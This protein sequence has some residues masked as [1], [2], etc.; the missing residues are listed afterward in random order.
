[1]TMTTALQQAEPAAATP[2]VRHQQ[3]FTVVVPVLRAALLLG[4]GG[5]FAL[6]AVLTLARLFHLPGALWW[7]ATAQAHGH[8]Q[9]YGWAGLFV[10]GVG[11]HFLPR[12]RGAPLVAPRAVPWLLGALMVSLVGRALGQ[13]LLALESGAPVAGVL[14]ALS[15][16]LELVALGGL[17]G[18]L[19][20]TL[21]GGPPAR[22]RKAFW[23]VAPFL[24]G[25]LL[26]LALS[27]LVNAGNTLRLGAGA[28]ALVPGSGDTLNISLGLFGFLVPMALAMSAQSLPMYAGLEVFPRRQLWPLAGIYYGGLA[29]YC[30]GMMTGSVAMS[31]LGLLGMGAALL[32]FIAAFLRMM[33]TRRRL[34][35]K[36]ANLAPA[37][38]A[39]QHGYTQQI[40]RN[41][42]A[43]GPFV[44]LV[45][46]AF[47]WALFAG[48]LLIMDGVAGVLGADPPFAM[49]A[50]RHA[51]AIGFVA[52]LI[53][54]IAPRMVPGFSGGK[55]ASPR[56]VTATLWLGNA[57][58]L[59]R[60]G[61]ILLAPLLARGAG[62]T[63]ESLLFGLSGPTG[64]A[65]AICLALN[66]WPALRS[67]RSG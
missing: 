1:M 48:A 37:P 30:A 4:A 40:A 36:V 14:V 57:S 13:P 29:T 44:A 47:V 66:L 5:G 31:G 61:S 28:S 53:C 63:V 19:G 12:L 34:P 65:L 10:L 24:A 27:A 60:V 23:G 35:K 22:T 6:A 58:A 3:P 39:A 49:D 42:D 67:A 26:A 64:L 33:R 62:L 25:A 7:L 52:L 15:A 41:R 51:L 9:L 2:S 45:A 16:L 50:V 20:A 55:I 32:T 56:Y 59:L 38:E 11:M 21:L 46:S 43:Y 8:L 17:V 54:G 18:I